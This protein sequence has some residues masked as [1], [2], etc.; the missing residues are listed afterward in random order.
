[1]AVPPLLPPPV[2]RVDPEGRAS[3]PQIEWETRLLGALELIEPVVYPE[4]LGAKGDGNAS[5][6]AG[7]DD[8]AAIQAALNGFPVVRGRPGKSYK[9]TSRITVPDGT[10]LSDIELL[11]P[12]ANFN[13]ASLALSERYAANACGIDASGGLT[14]PYTP[15][16]GVTLRGVTLRYQNTVGLSVSGITARNAEDLR[17]LDCELSGFPTGCGIRVATLSGRTLIQNNYVHDFYDNHDW[18]VGAVPNI[19]GIE[20]DNDIVNGVGSNNVQITGNHISDMIVGPVMLAAH[21]YQSDGINVVSYLA[22]G[23][24]IQG[25]YVEKCGEGIDYFGRFGT[26]QGNIVYDSYIYGIKVIHG[27]GF[28]SI[29]GN[30][31]ERSGLAGIVLSGS[32]SVSQ[33]TEG[34]VISGNSIFDIDADG[35]WAESTTACI[36]V[37]DQGATAY[38]SPIRNLFV[39]NTLRP[40][41]AKYAILCNYSGTDNHFVDNLI[42]AAGSLGRILSALGGTGHRRDANPTAVR[43]H[44]STSFTVGVDATATIP[45]NTET[46]DSRGELDTSTGKWTCQIPGNYRVSV[47]VRV[48]AIS[49]GREV[50]V[51]LVKNNSSSECVHVKYFSGTSDTIVLSDV[52]PLSSGDI[53]EVRV[54]HTDTGVVTFGGGS[55]FTNLSIEAV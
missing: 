55:A 7:T 41:D 38:K 50:T 8:T 27:G 33:Y 52:L 11:M 29:S 32:S 46:L 51:S 53:I 20:L 54:S 48:S 12:S 13:N 22:R 37:V 49:A 15:R 2:V 26:I 47:N 17:I 5:T 39:G 4:M 3:V 35:V 40:T 36:S 30:S 28:S 9:I 23:T 44:Y 10:E 14:T 21:G 42:Q 43:A 25:N 6:F 18:G 19:T 1:M 16:R 24:L 45:F 34:N 31:I